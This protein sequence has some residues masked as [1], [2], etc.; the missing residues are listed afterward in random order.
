MKDSDC[1]QL[2]P[3]FSPSESQPQ[4]VTVAL[5]GPMLKMTVMNTRCGWELETQN[6]LY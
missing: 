1:N 3:T 6:V 2:T 4:N 5:L